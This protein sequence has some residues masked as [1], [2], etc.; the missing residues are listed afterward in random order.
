[1]HDTTLSAKP[2]AAL[3][4]CMKPHITVQRGTG[5]R[6]SQQQKGLDVS[7]LQPHIEEVLQDRADLGHAGRWG[8]IG[9][10]ST[11]FAF[12]GCRNTS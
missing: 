1:M 9:N 11:A 7:S 3:G 8:A 6:S 12:G 2:Q 10:M 4:Q 5:C